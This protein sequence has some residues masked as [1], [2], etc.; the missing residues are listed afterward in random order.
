[1]EQKQFGW[2]PISNISTNADNC[3]SHWHHTIWKVCALKSHTNYNDNDK[4]AH[5]AMTAH[6]DSWGGTIKHILSQTI[7]CLL[8]RKINICFIQTACRFYTNGVEPILKKACIRYI[9][10]HF[11][12]V[13]VLQLTCKN[14][15]SNI[16]PYLVFCIFQCSCNLMQ[17]CN[18]VRIAHV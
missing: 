18:F 7:L 15:K 4:R 17:I 12:K 5:L 1:M 8:F 13:L 2:T 16:S 11:Q 3:S 14:W 6:R 9:S 10:P